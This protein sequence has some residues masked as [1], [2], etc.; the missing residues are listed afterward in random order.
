MLP[1]YN[2]SERGGQDLPLLF[3]CNVF[4][5]HLMHWECAEDFDL[6]QQG[7]ISPPLHMD[8]LI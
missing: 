1:L 6:L 5:F 2:M 3:L 4:D 8:Y 7:K